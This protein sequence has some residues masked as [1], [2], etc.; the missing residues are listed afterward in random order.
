MLDELRL[1]WQAHL[2]DRCIYTSRYL[3]FDQALLDPR[4]FHSF[5][6]GFVQPSHQPGHDFVRNRIGAHGDIISAR[7]SL[8]NVCVLI[9][10]ASL[11]S[12]SAEADKRIHKW[13]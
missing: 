9:E 12:E 5:R 6:N 8:W 11:V 10:L 13:L 1:V 4:P 2:T 7:R 3:E